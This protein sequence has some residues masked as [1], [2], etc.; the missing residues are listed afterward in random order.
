MLARVVIRI[1]QFGF[2]TVLLLA[3]CGKD[4]VE[5][6]IPRDQLP[7]VLLDV[8]VAESRANQLQSNLEEAR[9]E[10]LRKHGFDTADLNQ[11]I[12]ILTENPEIGKQVYQTLL[13]SAIFEQREI[14][15]RMMADSASQP[16]GD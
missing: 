4:Q 9:A 13:D 6:P 8:Y 16:G 5:T 2:Y 11:S 7:S 15:S 14:R 3:G 1:V 12:R 10:A